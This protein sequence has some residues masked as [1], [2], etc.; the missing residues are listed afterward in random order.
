GVADSTVGL[1]GAQRLSSTRRV[2]ALRG[3]PR[4][5]VQL[6]REREGRE[7]DRAQ[8][9]KQRQ[10]STHL[11]C[12][13]YRSVRLALPEPARSIP[14]IDEA[15]ADAPLA[16]FAPPFDKL[17]SAAPGPAF[18]SDPSASTP[19]PAC[20]PV[21]GTSPLVSG[22]VTLPPTSPVPGPRSPKFS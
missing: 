14:S 22:P 6:I 21:D 10:Y 5:R 4:S 2:R 12:S 18:L 8:Q 3:L 11:F 20:A 13:A 7:A 16:S 9:C 1:H 17:L 19:A 15:P